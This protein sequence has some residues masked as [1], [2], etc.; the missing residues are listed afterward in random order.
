MATTLNLC[1][2]SSSPPTVNG[3]AHGSSGPSSS[4][5]RNRST[6]VDALENA[7]DADGDG[8][9]P[10]GA[11]SIRA[12]GGVVSTVHRTTVGGP[13]APTSGTNRIRTTC[14]P[15]SRSVS[16]SGD[17]HPRKMPPSREHS[18]SPSGSPA[19]APNEME[20]DGP[21]NSPGRSVTGTASV[22]AVQTTCTRSNKF[23]F[24]PS[25]WKSTVGSPSTLRLYPV[26][27]WNRSSPVCSTTTV[28]PSGV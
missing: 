25:F 22:F 23:A 15:S 11:L 14:S 13:A 8:S 17:S 21:E 20:V 7:I 6:S 2:P 4:L 10:E 9:T 12:A 3:D 26:D 24:G 19:G 16:C 18:N 1:A 28:F 5:H 27:C